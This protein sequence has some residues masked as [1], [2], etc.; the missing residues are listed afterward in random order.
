SVNPK[1]FVASTRSR[2]SARTRSQFGRCSLARLKTGGREAGA[3]AG[4]CR[5]GG[6]VCAAGE[7]GCAAGGAGGAESAS[8]DADGPPGDVSSASAAVC[9][10]DDV[11]CAYSVAGTSSV[12]A[13]HDANTGLPSAGIASSRWNTEV[14]LHRT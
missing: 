8:N 10:G 6:V 1:P 14:S 7:A 3:G 13:T 5:G 4:A 12:P 9:V 2:N 11:A